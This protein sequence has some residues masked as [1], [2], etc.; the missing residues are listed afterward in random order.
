MPVFRVVRLAR[1]RTLNKAKK[2]RQ[3]LNVFRIPPEILGTSF[4]T[5]MAKTGK[6]KL[7]VEMARAGVSVFRSCIKFTSRRIVQCSMLVVGRFVNEIH[8]KL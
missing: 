3:D 1:W 5:K 2:E 4:T 8:H 6:C 7:W